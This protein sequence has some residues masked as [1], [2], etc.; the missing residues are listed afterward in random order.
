MVSIIRYLHHYN[1]QNNVELSSSA[2]IAS[3][4]S[5]MILTNQCFRNVSLYAMSIELLKS[6]PSFQWHC[7]VITAITVRTKR[8]W[9][10]GLS[11]LTTY[12]V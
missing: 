12:E 3:R 11:E 8:K 6:E 1:S 7:H 9:F 2:V 4:C 5:Q 10:N